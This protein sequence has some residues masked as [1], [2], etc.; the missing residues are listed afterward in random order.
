M[1]KSIFVW[2]EDGEWKAGDEPPIPLPA[3]VLRI[4]ED[5]VPRLVDHINEEEI[6]VQH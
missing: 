1:Y 3:M 6:K 5:L 2:V 4:D